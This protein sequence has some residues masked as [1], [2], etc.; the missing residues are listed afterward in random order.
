M[1]VCAVGDATGAPVQGTGDDADRRARGCGNYW[2]DVGLAFLPT[3]TLVAFSGLCPPLGAPMISPRHVVL[4][5]A[6]LAACG[7]TDAPTAPNAAPLAPGDM[8]PTGAGSVGQLRRTGYAVTG[9][10][11]L[12][13]VGN[14]ARLDLSSDFTIGQTPGPTIYLNTT[15]NPNTGQPLRIGALRSNRGAQSYTF[16]LPAGAPAYAWVVIWCDP[17]NAAMAEARLP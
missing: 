7:G 15:N 13:I 17:F 6:F 14:T 16:Q 3:G 9:S 1:V 11:T 10:A 2:S 12:T 4:L 5:V 8:A